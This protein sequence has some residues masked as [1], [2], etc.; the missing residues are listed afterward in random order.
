MKREKSTDPIHAKAKL[1]DSLGKNI[2]TRLIP[3]TANKPMVTTPPRKEKS[4]LVM[5]V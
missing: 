2:S 4:F 5:K 3:I 1:A